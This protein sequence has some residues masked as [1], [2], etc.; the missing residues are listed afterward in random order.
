MSGAAVSVTLTCPLLS[1]TQLSG[2]F[3]YIDFCAIMETT[4][5]SHQ[6]STTG[7]QSDVLPVLLLIAWCACD[8]GLFFIT[9]LLCFNYHSRPSWLHLSFSDRRRRRPFGAAGCFNPQSQF[10]DAN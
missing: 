1:L 5:E 4:S 2:S 7:G 8:S 6:G 10:G 3:A 9:C